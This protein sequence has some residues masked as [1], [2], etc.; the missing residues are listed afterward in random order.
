MG[1]SCTAEMHRCT[2]H[3]LYFI[4][5]K[6]NRIPP[7]TY[8]RENWKS[9]PSIICRETSAELPHE[10]WSTSANDVE[11][12][13]STGTGLL[14]RNPFKKGRTSSSSKTSHV[15]WNTNLQPQLRRSLKGKSQSPNPLAMKMSW[16][17]HSS[18][19]TKQYIRSFK[20]WSNIYDN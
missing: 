14:A 8:D 18:H 17:L 13:L 10:L 1:N 4:V 2:Q 16:F 15:P 6:L 5:I 7:E 11:R 9:F 3:C 20:P 12:L 19:K